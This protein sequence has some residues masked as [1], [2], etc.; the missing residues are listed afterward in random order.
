SCRSPLPRRRQ[1]ALL[2]LERQIVHPPPVLRGE[3][4]LQDGAGGLGRQFTLGMD[5]PFPDRRFGAGGHDG[6]TMGREL[7]SAAA[8]SH[9]SSAGH[10]ET[11]VLR[12]S[13]VRR[14]RGTWCSI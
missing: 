5:D 4:Q 10:P 12:P 8:V 14:R 11:A 13:A 6:G 9:G 7:V 2:G 3:G 1:R